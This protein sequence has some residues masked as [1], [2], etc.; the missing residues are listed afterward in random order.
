MSEKCQK[1]TPAFHA[2][3]VPAFVRYSNTDLPPHGRD[4][5]AMSSRF[6]S[7]IR[8]AKANAATDVLATA[9][10]LG[11]FYE[12][13]SGAGVVVPVGYSFKRAHFFGGKASSRAKRSADGV[14]RNLQLSQLLMRDELRPVG[15]MR[16]PMHG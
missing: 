11:E 5:K 15:H 16:R 8:S 10:S 4:D 7:K 1:Q 3:D 2:S 13:N 12:G 6:G 9:S 14:R